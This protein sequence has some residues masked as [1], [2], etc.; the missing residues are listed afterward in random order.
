M[1]FIIWYLIIIERKTIMC[2]RGEQQHQHKTK[3]KLEKK[4]NKKAQAYLIDVVTK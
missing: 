1:I 4:S 3:Q 2:L